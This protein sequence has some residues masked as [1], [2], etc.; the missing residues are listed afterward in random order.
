[1][2]AQKNIV[3]ETNLNLFGPESMKGWGLAMVAVW[4][5]TMLILGVVFV[6]GGEAE[7]LP[8]IALFMLAITTGLGVMGLLIML[9]L[10]RGS[11]PVRYTLSGKGIRMQTLSRAARRSNRLAIALGMLSGKPGVLGA[12]LIAQSRET[13]T[14]SWRGAFRLETRPSRQLIMLKGAWRTLMQVQC[15]PD[16]YEQVLARI[17]EE[18]RRHRTLERMPGRFPLPVFLGRT[19]LVVLASLPIFA[20]HTEYDLD[21]LLPVIMFCFALATIWLIPLFGWVVLGSLGLIVF[22]L[23]VHLLEENRSYIRPGQ[24][25]TLL[26][27]MNAED[28]LLL[29]LAILGAAGL[30]WLALGALRGRIPSALMA[31]RLDKG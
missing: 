4:L 29:G 7:A 22:T 28:W 19:A 14:L 6:A 21:I 1:M 5:V 11:Y 10:F 27:V 31:D 15:R 2:S 24:T 8:S 12:G 16:N 26:E 9:L 13:E 30:A 25:Y 18:M 20:V 17:R 3:W 23:V